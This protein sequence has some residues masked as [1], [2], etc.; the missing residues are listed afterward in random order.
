MVVLVFH[1]LTRKPEL[2]IS[3]H[4]PEQFERIICK[5][6]QLGF[7]NGHARDL[8]NPA[9]DAKKLLI[10]FDDGYAGV[11]Q[12]ALPVLQKYGFTALVFLVAGY[13]EKKSFWDMN[14]LQRF[15]H[16]G[17]DEV[18]ELQ[19]AGFE[20]GSHTMSHPDLTYASPQRV[21]WELRE[22]KQVLETRLGPI[23]SFSYPFGR[24]NN[25]V[26]ASVRRADYRYAFTIYPTRKRGAFDPWAVKRTPV[27]CLD[28]WWLAKAELLNPDSLFGRMG[29][30]KGKLVNFLSRG[31]TLL[32]KKDYRNELS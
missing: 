11:Y 20:F 15:K 25:E 30:T 12:Y 32:R 31:T 21:E 5:V 18:L 26:K 13:L 6:K 3:W 1:K 28:P 23:H 19:Q 2:G 7:V 8:S 9:S 17:W 4:T 14:I 22:S 29:E 16:L 24:Y 27:H 10:T